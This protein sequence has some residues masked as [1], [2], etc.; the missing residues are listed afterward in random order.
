VNGRTRT[1]R[2]VEVVYGASDPPADDPAELFHEASKA[3]PSLVATQLQGAALLAARED[4]RVSATRSV[5]RNPELEWRSLPPPLPLATPLEH[6]LRARRSQREFTQ[7]PLALAELAT[8]LHAAYG[9]TAAVERGQSF[10]AVPSGGAL[11]P[12]ELY[13]VAAAIAALPRGIYHYDPLRSS[14]GLVSGAASVERFED[15]SAYPD[16]T[17]A[18]A[19]TVL[20]AAVFWRSRFKYGLRGY[21]FALLEAGH[22]VQNLVLAATALGLASVPLGGYYDRRADEL[23]HLD[24][25]N[26]STV[27]AACVGPAT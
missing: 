19:V 21:R 26:D 9:V 25:V 15:A 23:L 16:I 18:A 4:V 8:L 27:Y 17:S 20:V 5:R 3:Y 24:G 6:V 1:V 7:R 10:R 12:L 22:V 2:S 14:I 13:V 11:Y